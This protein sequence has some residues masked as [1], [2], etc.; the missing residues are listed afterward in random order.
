MFFHIQGTLNSLW[1]GHI[2]RW[3]KWKAN[4]PTKKEKKTNSSWESWLWLHRSTPS[5]FLSIT[6]G[7]TQ[8]AKMWLSCSDLETQHL[9]AESKRAMITAE[10]SEP[11]QWA[12]CLRKQ[13]GLVLLSPSL[14]TTPPPP[15]PHLGPKLCCST[16]PVVSRKY[17]SPWSPLLY[18]LAKI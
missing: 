11:G 2:E 3:H 8:A 17:S 15:L 4:K 1:T 14:T 10:V 18:P 6:R 12:W 7:F 13:A 5:T 9:L 16:R